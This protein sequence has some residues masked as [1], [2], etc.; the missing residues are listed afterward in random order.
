MSWGPGSR[1]GARGRAW[2]PSAYRGARLAGTREGGAGRMVS[3]PGRVERE[4]NETRDPAQEAR[5]ELS[6]R[7]TGS[8]AMVSA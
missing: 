6:F 4:R 5:S 2:C 7:D 1:L 8:V 3:C